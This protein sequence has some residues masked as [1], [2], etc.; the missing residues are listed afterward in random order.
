MTESTIQKKILLPDEASRMEAGK[1]GDIN[2]IVEA[3]A[4]TGKTS[5]LIERILSVIISGSAEIHEIVAITFTEKAASEMITRL[6]DRLELFVL[7]GEGN[8]KENIE[9]LKRAENAL[10]SFERH[11]IS[12]I[13]SLSRAILRET[14][15]EAGVDPEFQILD[16]VDE[17][18]I[19]HELWEEWIREHL[20][21]LESPFH[22]GY[23]VGLRTKF[24]NELFSDVY[25]IRDQM[26]ELVIDTQSVDE[27]LESYWNKV[28]NILNSLSLLIVSCNVPEG[29][30]GRVQI[31]KFHRELNFFA[32]YD[33]PGRIRS[34]LTWK[35]DRADLGDKKSWG[36][37][38]EEKKIL[39]QTLRET[40]EE[41]RFR[42]SDSL[43]QRCIKLLLDFLKIIEEEKFRRRVLS[44]D[45]TLIKTRN[46]L[47]DNG[48]I[49]EHYKQ[50]FRKILVDEFQDTDPLQAEIVFF[51]AE[52][53][54]RY[55]KEW[56]L[57]SLKDGKLF[58]VG[59]P[60]QSIYSFRRADIEIYEKVKSI[61]EKNGKSL[62][63]TVNFR[64]LSPVIN[65]V[66]DQFSKLIVRPESGENY[67]PH[68]EPLQAFRQVEPEKYLVALRPTTELILLLLSADDVRQ[69]ASETVSSF[70]KKIVTEKSFFVQAKGEKEKHPICYRDIAIL[71]RSHHEME[72]Y[73]QSLQ[74]RGVPY[75]LEGGKQFYKRPEIREIVHT[76]RAI[77][78]PRDEVSVVASLKSP[79]FSF[80]DE[81]ILH[82]R[83]KDIPLCY[84]DAENDEHPAGDAFN[85]LKEFH[86]KRNHISIGH[87]LEEL[88]DRTHIRDF[89]TSAFSSERRTANLDKLLL[90]AR[91]Q[92]RQENCTLRSFI[93]H[94]DK[95]EDES[96]EEP[97]APLSEPGTDAIRL[98][99][100][101]KS[102]GLEFPVVILAASVG[103][104]NAQ[105][106]SS[107]FYD[108]EKNRVEL[109][110][111]I[112]TTTNF[113]NF[114]EMEKARSLAEEIRLLYVGCTRARDVLVIPAFFKFDITKD[115][116]KFN[117]SLF[118]EM[119]LDTVG[120]RVPGTAG[121][122][123]D[124]PY[125]L[126]SHFNWME[127]NR[128]MSEEG[129]IIPDILTFDNRTKP[130]TT[131]FT[132]DL[133]EWENRRK[134]II[135]T[136]SSYREWTSYTSEKF[137]ED[138]G[139]DEEPRRSDNR[140]IRI[141]RAFHAVMEFVDFRGERP[142]EQLVNKACRDEG[143]GESA[144][145]VLQLVKTTL[146]SKIIMQAVRSGNYHREFQFSID[147]DGKFYNGAVDLL[148][149]DEE[150]LVIVDFKTDKVSGKTPESA[151]K[152]Y[153][154]QAG[155]YRKAIEKLTGS[156]VKKILYYFVRDDKT[157]D[158]LKL[159]NTT[160]T[161]ISE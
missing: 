93:K 28:E 155:I 62:K 143:V 4:G 23:H 128:E 125:P 159:N 16:D 121:D 98:M 71:F 103:G 104:T 156:P 86:A 117:H 25:S 45:D 109:H 31:E 89:S 53:E 142:L 130:A 3:G 87:L 19:I 38:K 115:G 119:L 99:T 78:N 129:K 160:G 136:G 6:R 27:I 139:W 14:P 64:T 114:K 24:F 21:D 108:R 58:I 7:S 118:Q 43:F 153:A 46:L 51:L 73:E 137:R 85:L 82:L 83:V 126:S 35:T 2:I 5:I 81:D 42:V 131:I 39:C 68:Y 17:K 122:E 48:E 141:G 44:F 150:G 133:T 88:F 158:M 116:P 111:D 75:I 149:K 124:E 72:Y 49:R 151:V 112:F 47:R 90:L 12:T 70:I 32:N 63:I 113:D 11:N 34:L 30:K 154:D 37:S 147:I 127:F 102:K 140:E 13:H 60:K 135:E 66:N 15:F 74:A 138:R 132:D 29:D 84:T 157:V 69:N 40:L 10:K 20:E 123:V 91:Q 56:S 92:D 61:I 52:E 57:C 65:W 77:D 26:E 97:D 161:L 22:L 8:E 110:Q 41:F 96:V 50:K 120:Y 105:K 80:S 148:Y 144:E 145:E 36:D 95:A 59:D 146:G 33:K 9:E 100:L 101:H 67:Q 76:L 1:D 55:E 18:E 106:V 54:D 94:I 79:M 134:K 107:F 152:N